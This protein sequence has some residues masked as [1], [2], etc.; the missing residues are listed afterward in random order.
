MDLGSSLPFKGRVRVGMG[1]GKCRDDGLDDG[2]RF[3]QD[4][5]VPETQYPEA[6]GFKELCPLVVCAGGF[7]MLPAVEFDN[8]F[9]FQTDKIEHVVVE[10]MLAAKLCSELFAAQKLPKLAFCIGS[11]VAKLLRNP[12]LPQP[13]IALSMHFVTHPPPGLPLEGGGA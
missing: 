5:I 6:A 1:C 7:C 13:L 8:H 10:G 11:M 3:L 9:L 4:L 12:V 2:F